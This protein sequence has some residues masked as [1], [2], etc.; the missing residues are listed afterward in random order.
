MGIIRYNDEEL[1][2]LQA[3][4][5]PWWDVS[6]R[7]LL[8]RVAPGLPS[9]EMDE[10]GNLTGFFLMSHPN[11]DA[12]DQYVLDVMRAGWEFAK[13]MENGTEL[14]QYQQSMDWSVW[15]QLEE[16]VI[17][18]IVSREEAIERAKSYII[19]LGRSLGVEPPSN[20]EDN[21]DLLD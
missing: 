13:A 6:A 15:R 12:M 20:D 10:D 17:E 1:V 19:A 2:A 16:Q 3:N 21:A 18:G 7:W 11:I 4:P 9:P 5:L 8:G 14:I